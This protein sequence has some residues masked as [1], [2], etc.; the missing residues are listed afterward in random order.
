MCG[1]SDPPEQEY[2]TPRWLRPDGAASAR[3]QVPQASTAA[4][5]SSSSSSPGS[6]SVPA[7]LIVE[8]MPITY[9]GYTYQHGHI[10][11]IEG[12][13]PKPV[14]IV[15]P[16]YAGLK[17]F[18]ID[19]CC[20][21][22]RCGYAAMC[23]DHYEDEDDYSFADRNPRRSH[24]AGSAIPL[25]L[26]PDQKRQARTHF[27]GAFTRMNARLSDPAHWRGLMRANLEM[28][29]EHPAVERGLA[30]AIGYC[31]GGQAVL[32]Q[33]RAGHQLQAV[34]SFHGLLH[35]KPL[36][37]NAKGHVDFGA[38]RVSDQEFADTFFNAENS[39][40]TDCK[41]LIE[42]GDLDDEVPQA[43][44]DAWKA[45]M[46]AHSIDWRFHN[47]ARTPHGFALAAGVWSTAYHE[48]A[49]RRSTLAMLSLFAEVW[50]DY[51]QNPVTANACGT[52]LGQAIV[53]AAKL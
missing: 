16:N 48:P 14:V 12:A 52:V 1:P 44:I 19:Q 13:G 28:A 18:D 49:D 40:D 25:E 41:V 26:N 37:L 29:F 32:E 30:A 38:G 36:K 46:D 15:H 27:I 51:P 43:D 53:S 6:E 2:A 10:A 39:Y 11:Y 7:R 22:A 34:V 3:V 33:V 31:F 17:Q 23:V 9:E 21:L 4:S 5:S 47:H 20:F 50:P 42:N 24:H 8:R 45:E 35:S